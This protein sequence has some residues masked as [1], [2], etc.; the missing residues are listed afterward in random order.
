MG[1]IEK[2]LSRVEKQGVPVTMMHHSRFF[3]PL[4]VSIF[5]CARSSAD[6]RLVDAAGSIS[7]VGLLQV[8][9]D[10]GFGT[11]CGANPAAADVVC[12]ALGYSYGSVSTSPCGFYGGANLCG[13][14][15]SPV[16]MADLICSGSEWSLEECSWSTPDAACSAH[17]A[18]TLIYCGKSGASGQTPNGATRLIAPDGAPALDGKGRPEV[19]L[20]DVWV[21]ICSSGISSGAGAVICKS[22]G[23]R[24]AFDEVAKCTSKGSCGEVPPGL[25]EL[26]CSGQESNVLDCP[27]T[28]DSDVFCAPSESILVSC[29]GAGETQGRPAKEAAPQPVLKEGI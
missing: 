5:V 25:S 24:G 21:P 9:T 6:V 7:N 18:D 27:H 4:L 23:F 8:R 11:V 15:G 17:S 14:P 19:Y 16:A 2:T 29:A 13:A 22:M 3:L 28:A 26:A 10:A 20:K 1:E 12:R